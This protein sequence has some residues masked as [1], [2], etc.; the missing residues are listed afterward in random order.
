MLD[1]HGDT[2]STS[3][4]WTTFNIGSW[5]CEVGCGIRLLFGVT[6]DYQKG[7]STAYVFHFGPFSL[8]CAQYYF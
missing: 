4:V 5:H 2:M 8:I 1:Y 7:H 6:F 3:S